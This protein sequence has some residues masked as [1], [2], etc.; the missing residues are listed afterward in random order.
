MILSGLRPPGEET[1][2]YQ[3]HC[4]ATSQ[5][6]GKA[7]PFLGGIHPCLLGKISNEGAEEVLAEEAPEGME[8]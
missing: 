4:K 6:L 5:E 1:H 7:K 3:A 2:P 8:A